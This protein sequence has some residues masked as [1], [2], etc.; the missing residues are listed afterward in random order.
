MQ[1]NDKK[2]TIDGAGD[3]AHR[4]HCCCCCCDA[5]TGPSWEDS[6]Q[7]LESSDPAQRL[8]Y[9]HQGPSSPLAKTSGRM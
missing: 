5:V 2:K 7:D 4:Y 3:M 9:Q 6:Y 1:H 8:R